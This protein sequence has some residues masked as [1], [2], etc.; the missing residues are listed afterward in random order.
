[1]HGVKKSPYWTLIADEFLDS[2]IQEQ[3]SLCVRYINLEEKK[4]EEQFLEMKRI[5]GH[6]NATNI[7][8]AVMEAIIKDD[9][10]DSLPTEKLVGLTTDGASV[11][12]FGKRRTVWDDERENKSEAFFYPLPSSPS[13]SFIKDE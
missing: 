10:R 12:I 8:S 4:I 2:A 7:F 11:M 5:I 6:P 3:L 13:Y 9:V 1:M